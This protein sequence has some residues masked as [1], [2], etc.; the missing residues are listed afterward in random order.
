[1]DLY[2]SM[3]THCSKTP[4]GKQVMSEVDKIL[5]DDVLMKHLAIIE[6]WYGKIRQYRD[7]FMDYVINRKPVESVTNPGE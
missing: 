1:M 3:Y 7:V 5:T 2:T 6:R 4:V